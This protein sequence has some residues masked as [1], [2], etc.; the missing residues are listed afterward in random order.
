MSMHYICNPCIYIYIYMVSDEAYQHAEN[1]WNVLELENMG[2][3]HV[4]YL[5]KS[6]VL[7]LAD[8][9]ENFRRTCR[10]HYKLDPCHYF[11]SPGLACMGCNA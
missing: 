6:D 2:G 10:Q 5:I 1:V 8:V 9:F 3:Y 11:T 7:L 4:L